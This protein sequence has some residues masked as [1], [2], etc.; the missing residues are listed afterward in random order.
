MNRKTILMVVLAGVIFL[1][2]CNRRDLYKEPETTGDT[3]V[4]T[5]EIQTDDFTPNTDTGSPYQNMSEEELEALFFETPNRAQLSTD[6]AFNT[7]YYFI[8]S[9]S[10][11]GTGGQAYSK[12]TG[13][14]ITLCKDLTC[15]HKGDDPCLYKGLIQECVVVGNR[16][17]ILVNNFRGEYLL[18]SVNLQLDDTKLVYKW[19][20][21]ENI[22][23]LCSYNGKIYMTG[24]V[25]ENGL[26]I[27]LSMFIFD[28]LK[29]T[30]TTAVETDFMFQAGS[31]ID[32]VLYYTNQDGSLWQY[33]IETT[34]HECLLE[35]SLLNRENGDVRFIVSETAESTYLRIVRQGVVKDSLLYYDL[36][37]GKTFPEEQL[38]EGINGKIS[39]WTEAGQFYLLNHAT[40]AYES[41]P[42]FAYYN[43]KVENWLVND[44]G[45]EI[46]YRQNTDDEL[47]LFTVMK[48]DGIP[49]AIRAIAAM[50]GKTIVVTYSSYKDF[51]NV[52]NEYQKITEDDLRIRYAVIDLETGAVYKNDLVY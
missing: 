48:T 45:G 46:W 12:L 39:A 21:T 19:S 25:M 18:Y 31:I 50:D 52:Y 27:M 5:N 49:D 3:D 51:A 29:K 14:M 44:S 40:T 20:D 16:I 8:L 6:H 43:D 9:T 37:T 35:A 30:Y 15:S 23:N 24:Y 33:D 28:P 4:V 11:F 13:N 7:P 41:D 36:N 38:M 34:V 1:S 26:N 47:T 10:T 32:G 22:D 2:A 17:Y 42:H